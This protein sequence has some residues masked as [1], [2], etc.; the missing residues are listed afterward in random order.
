M[1]TPRVLKRRRSGQTNYHKRLKMVSSETPRFVVRPTHRGI[2]A[3]VISFSPEGDRVISTVTDRSLKKL[4][5]ET[6]GNNTPISYLVGYATGLK[7]K[8]Q[9][10]GSAILDTGRYNITTGGRISAAL[11]GFVDAG[12]EIPYDEKIFP[13]ESRIKGEHLKKSVINI[14]EAKSKLEESL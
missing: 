13:D 8:K 6:L 10:V 5:L 7:A 4:G 11:K 3:Q 9:N 1:K 2:S 14:E 12:I